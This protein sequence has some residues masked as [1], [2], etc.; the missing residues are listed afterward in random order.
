VLPV[1]E[2]RDSIKTVAVVCSVRDEKATIFGKPISNVRGW[3]LAGRT[4][5]TTGSEKPERQENPPDRTITHLF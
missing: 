4:P 5:A 1:A 3:P 2:S